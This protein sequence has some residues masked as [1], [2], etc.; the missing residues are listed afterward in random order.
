MHTYI[1]RQQLND[2]IAILIY[3]IHGIETVKCKSCAEFNDIAHIYSHQ[4]FIAAR[5][6]LDSLFMDNGEQ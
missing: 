5:G 2:G 4:F 6:S 1:C 3:D